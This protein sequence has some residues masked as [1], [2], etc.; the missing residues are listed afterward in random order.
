[1][2][3]E[4]V[5][6]RIESFFENH[7]FK[8][9]REAPV[10]G[11]RVD[12]LAERDEK[13]FFIECKGDDYLR[14][15]ELHVMIGQIV[16]EMYEVSPDTHYCLALPFSLATYLRGFGIEGIKAL[17]LHLII[18]IDTGFWEEEVCYLDT[19]DTSSFIQA[20]KSGKT[21]DWY[22]RLLN[23]RSHPNSAE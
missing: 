1:M 20:L 13:K 5:K 21:Q 8:V 22:L 15:H 7:G 9:K 10:Y 6:S 17:K 2:N 23:L 12:L 19:E 4:E 11:Y 16:S 14:S 18:V 3:E